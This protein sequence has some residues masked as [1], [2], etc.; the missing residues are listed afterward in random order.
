MARI[1][2]YKA[3]ALLEYDEGGRQSV[4]ILADKSVQFNY[5]PTGNTVEKYRTLYSMGFIYDQVY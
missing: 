1:Y 3:R 4:T 5:Q 2:G